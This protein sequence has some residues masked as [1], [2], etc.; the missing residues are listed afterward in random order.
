MF[1]RAYQLDLC[2]RGQE[3]CNYFLNACSDR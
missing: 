3:Y 1:R 2:H